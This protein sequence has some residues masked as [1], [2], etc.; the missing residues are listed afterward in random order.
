MLILGGSKD[1]DRRAGRPQ[2]TGIGTAGRH[3]RCGRTHGEH[4]LARREFLRHGFLPVHMQ[5][6]SLVFVADTDIDVS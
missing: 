2:E 1:P 6:E 3:P 5:V 4:R